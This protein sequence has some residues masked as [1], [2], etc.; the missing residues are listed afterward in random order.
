MDFEDLIEGFDGSIFMLLVPIGALVGAAVVRQAAKR[1]QQ[2]AVQYSSTVA[3]CGL[4]GEQIARRLLGEC[5]LDA[6]AVVCSSRRDLYHPAN[7]E[8]QLTPA[9]FAGQSLVA[10]AIAAHEV[11]HAQQYAQKLLLCRLRGISWRICQVFVIVALLLLLAATLMPVVNAASTVLLLRVLS[12]VV[13]PVVTLVMLL[14]LL[15]VVLQVVVTL[16]MERDASR[17]ARSL[18]RGAGLIAADEE[19]VIERVLNAAWRTY[20]AAGVQRGIGLL[21]IGALIIV[22]P[23][24]LASAPA[25]PDG[26]VLDSLPPELR[27]PTRPFLSLPIVMARLVAPVVI[28]VVLLERLRA[29]RRGQPTRAQRAAAHNNAAMALYIRGDF[30]RAIRSLDQTIALAPTE[31]VSY[32]NRASAWIQLREWDHALADL[33]AAI[34]RG[35]GSPENYRMRGNIWLEKRDYLRAVADFSAAVERAPTDSAVFRDR[36]LAL[37]FSGNLDRALVDLDEAIRLNV[38]DAVAFNNRGVTWMR[39]GDYKQAFE[40]LLEAIRLDSKFPNPLKHLAW[41]QATCPCAEL[42]QGDQAVANATRALELAGG[43][44]VEWLEVL[45]AAHAEA[46]NFEEAVKW[47]EKRLEGAHPEERD[48]AETRLNLYRKRQPFHTPVGAKG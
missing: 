24:P 16:P 31:P 18:A 38:T 48:E 37:L 10:L 17:R 15:A 30:A 28:G 46:G 4:T 27:L 2:V 12:V 33:D 41:L 25:L 19:P 9:N 21:L 35:G 7:R 3:A 20:A 6:V 45:A 39:R 42:R 34:A 14:S 11:G 5:G 23:I 36:G 8:V 1:F 22:W 43:K 29:A 47:Q 26:A 40:D 32:A 44:P 13:Q